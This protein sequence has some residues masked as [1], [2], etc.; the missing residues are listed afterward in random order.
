MKSLLFVLLILLSL[1]NFT[2]A[3]SEKETTFLSFESCRI[4][5]S[6]PPKSA[7]ERELNEWILDAE[8]LSRLEN[9]DAI[10]R[11]L[12]LDHDLKKIIPDLTDS[13]IHEW[14]ERMIVHY[15]HERGYMP[16]LTPE[17][18]VN[19]PDEW[20]APHLTSSGT[21]ALDPQG[22]TMHLFEISRRNISQGH[23]GS[24]Q[25]I[26]SFEKNK[27][28]QSMLKYSAE[29]IRLWQDSA[30]QSTILLEV[31]NRTDSKD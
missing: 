25:I 8:E 10:D 4:M 2:F 28:Y 27:N 19:T 7:A 24:L 26:S 20:T 3:A 9:K 12:T 11:L 14:L 30:L 17:I 15:N 1:G 13:E 23:I 6:A 21:I 16:G 31:K 5:V 22:K 18:I 29:L